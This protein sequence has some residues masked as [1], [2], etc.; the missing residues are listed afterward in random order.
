M[1]NF[2]DKL[3]FWEETYPI[4]VERDVIRSGRMHTVGFNKAVRIQSGDK[5]DVFELETGERTSP[6][7]QEWQEIDADGK[8]YVRVLETE[9]E[10]LIPWNPKFDNPKQYNIDEDGDKEVEPADLDTLMLDN[11]SERLNFFLDEIKRKY[12]KYRS[13]SWLSEHKDL[14]LVITT[15]VAITLIIYA[16]GSTFGEVIPVINQLMDKIG[17]LT[18]ALQSAGSAPPS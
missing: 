13:G 15:A 3:K 4:E 12:E 1:P 17:G 5:G 2:I 14:A 10:E 9:D 11:K 6:V 18:Q 16:A 8:T 7:K